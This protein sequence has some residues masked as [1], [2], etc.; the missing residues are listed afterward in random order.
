MREVAIA[1]LMFCVLYV[2][3]GILRKRYDWSPS[4]HYDIPNDVS[5][6]QSQDCSHVM[7]MGE[8][9]PICPYCRA[10]HFR[11]SW[12][13]GNAQCAGCGR[14]FIVMFRDGA[15][16]GVEIPEDSDTYGWVDFL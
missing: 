8:P 11:N 1:A 7:S 14:E 4:L 5:P 3:V 9:M 13:S 15:M 10:G 16:V 6:T 2:L 12:G